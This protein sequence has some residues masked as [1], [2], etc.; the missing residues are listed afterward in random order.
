[1]PTIRFRQNSVHNLSYTGTRN[2]Q[3]I[4]WD[5]NLP[6]FG[7]RVY[8]NGRRSYVCAYRVRNRK[9]IATL[10][11]VDVL[12]LEQARKKA[13]SFLGH[14]ANGDDPQATQDA[15][16]ASS[17]IK[18]LSYEYIER[19][20]KQKK[21][22]WKDDVS[23]LENHIIPKLGVRLAAAINSDDVAKLHMEIGREFPYAANR[24]LDLIR[25]MFNLARL[26]R[27][28]PTTM[29][30]PASG[31]ER[32][33]EKKRRR[34]V[35][36]VEMPRLVQALEG[37]FNEYA[38]HALWLLLLTGLRSNELLRAKWTDIDWDQR[39]LFVGKTKNGES[40]LAPLSYAAIDRLKKI[41]HTQN[42]PYII[43]G[44]TPGNHLVNL[45]KPWRRIRKA[46]GIEDVRIHDLRRTVG[47]WL[48]RSGTS[49]HLVGAVLN[50]K[51][52]KTTARYAYFQTEDRTQVLDAH[53]D[54]ITRSIATSK[55]SSRLSSRSLERFAS[56]NH[57]LSKRCHRFSREELHKLVW[58]FP[59]LKIAA[60]LGVSDV[61]L[62]KACRRSNIPIPPR[63]YWAKVASGQKPET[64]T[65]PPQSHNHSREVTIRISSAQRTLRSEIMRI[66]IAA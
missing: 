52:Q 25:K 14:A 3:C 42:N 28:I 60:E 62:A 65:L 21:K 43:C 12:T 23:S 56:T 26:W 22:S 63:G 64:T 2:A 4:Y 41:P 61:A 44:S 47:S 11:R 24:V 40:V 39:T 20:A 27:L 19:H 13:R 59:I 1:M 7:L 31:V 17:T 53:G 57:Y 58:S 6:C 46:A 35:T 55:S 37:E 51:D 45:Q 8:P 30:N 49:L 50:H 29:Q 38:R 36:T 32:F 34:F 10:G 66:T 48:A 9:R 15:I 33:P 54:K 5:E 16:H 18:A